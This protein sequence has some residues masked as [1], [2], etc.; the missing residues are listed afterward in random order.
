MRKCVNYEKNK[1]NARDKEWQATLS[2]RRSGCDKKKALK[3]IFRMKKLIWKFLKNFEG[4][5]NNF[6]IKIL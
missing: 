3:T 5:E 4:F 2:L 1:V 6:W